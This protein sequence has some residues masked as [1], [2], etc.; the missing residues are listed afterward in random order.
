M[1]A[2]TISFEA[3]LAAK[4]SASWAFWAMCGTWFSGLVTLF[5]ACVALKAMGAWKLQERRAEGK[6][7]KTAL[8]NYRNLSFILPNR[9]DPSNPD[10][11]R[12]AAFASQGAMNQVWSIVTIMEIDL[13]GGNKIGS[14]YLELYEVHSEY[15]CGKAEHEKVMKVLFSFLAMP[16]VNSAN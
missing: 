3:M 16:F 14:K 12:D 6:S 7:L 8:I 15:M 2:D 5:A 11:F 4:E 10:A 9:I 13:S 1:D